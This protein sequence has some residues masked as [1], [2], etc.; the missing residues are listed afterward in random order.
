M[1]SYL[2]S[3]LFCKDES[4]GLFCLS[5]AE[6]QRL[7]L[8]SAPGFEHGSGPPISPEPHQLASKNSIIS[9]II[10]TRTHFVA[11]KQKTSCRKYKQ[12]RKDGARPS[13]DEPTAAL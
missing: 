13:L 6:P 9:E 7:L 12:R 4:E 2:V 5:L 1:K 11:L 8:N 10:L 3:L